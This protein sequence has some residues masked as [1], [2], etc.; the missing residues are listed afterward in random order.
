MARAALPF[1]FFYAVEGYSTRGKIMGRQ[2]AGE[3]LLRAA[4]AFGGGGLLHATGSGDGDEAAL[5]ESLIAQGSN[6]Q[7]RWHPLHRP[8]S[9]A[10]VGAVYYPSPPPGMMAHLRNRAGPGSFSIFGVTHT[11]SSDKAMSALSDLAL[12]PFKPWDAIVCTSQVTRQVFDLLRART[13]EAFA[14]E[15]GATHFPDVLAPIIPL[16]VATR[17]FEANPRLRAT[18][19]DALGFGADTVMVLSLGRLSFHAK[20]NPAPLYHA[21]EN[22]PPH[23]RARA[24]LVECGVH[25]NDQI[26]NAYRAA[27]RQL[28]PSVRCLKADGADAALRS[29]L[30]QA[31]DLFVSLSDNIQET[32]GL[33]PVE[34]MASGLPVLATDWN[35]YRDTVRDG[36]DGFLIPTVSAA[37]GMGEELALRHAVRADS[38]D[39]YIGRASLATACDPQ[40]LAERLAELI[41]DADLRRRMGEA[42][43]ARAR[44]YFDWTT[45][46]SAYRDLCGRLADIR[47]AHECDAPQPWPARPDPFALF[48]TSP[49]RTLQADDAIRV[50]RDAGARLGTLTRLAMANYGFD[51]ELLPPALIH[52]LFAKAGQRPVWPVGEL[53]AAS[54]HHEAVAHRAL[55]WLAK[56]DLIAISAADEDTER[57]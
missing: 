52:A 43:R 35:G 33:S 16:G 25:A 30:W 4:A 21:L 5:R 42:G 40:V 44:R 54:G 34:A 7:V 51:E 3:N 29:G 46:L 38:Y 55:L 31:A 15:T 6:A 48:A 57:R 53:I 36:V 11:L 45:I 9:L 56:F 14:R 39:L 13:Q 19:R 8:E 17:D 28:M 47:R 23:L 50:P 20:Y 26:A 12:P 49:T 27:Q 18:T 41:G 1:A 24:V 32:Y 10:K 22:L 2:V 37:P